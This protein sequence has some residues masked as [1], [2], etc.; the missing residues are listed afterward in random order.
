MYYV[1]S[2]YYN[3][4]I[5]RFIS[6]DNVYS[7]ICATNGLVECNL[8]AYCDNNPVLRA[9]DGGDF[10]NIVAG[11]LIGA[12][13]NVAVTVGVGLLQKSKLSAGEIIISAVTG[14]IGGMMASSGM[15]QGAVTVAS[16]VVGT[17]ESLIKDLAIKKG[18]KDIDTI[19]IDAMKSGVIAGVAGYL[20]GSGIA[21]E[22]PMLKTAQK[23]YNTNLKTCLKTA[24][25]R[26]DVVTK[27][28]VK[29]A[30]TVSGKS[31]YKLSMPKLANTF[32]KFVSVSVGAALFP[33]NNSRRMSG[34]TM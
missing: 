11:A 12:A 25:T 15:P 3:P 5:C 24:V 18:T 2:R 33:K 30:L 29:N 1:E 20:G 9:D 4:D 27:K 32:I 28:I 10:W 8:F 23:A 16:M 26:T 19:M 31:C 17:A 6:S 7:G 13:V 14:A 22:N 34:Y 21:H